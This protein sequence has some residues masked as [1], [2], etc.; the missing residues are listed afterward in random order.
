MHSSTCG[1]A[2]GERAGLPAQLAAGEVEVLDRDRV[3]QP[4][5]AEH[6]VEDRHPAVGEV[7]HLDQRGEV[8]VLAGQPAAQH[9]V[10]AGHHLDAGAGEVGV[11]VARG[12]E[13]RLARRQLQVVAHQRDD[14][15]RVAG[16]GLGERRRPAVGVDE[17]RVV[18][19]HEAGGRLGDR[20]PPAPCGACRESASSCGIAARRPPRASAA[21]V[22]LSS[23]TW[24][25]A[26]Q[27]SDSSTG[28]NPHSAS[29]VVSASS[30]SGLWNGSLKVRVGVVVRDAGGLL[31]GEAGLGLLVRRVRLQRQRLLGGEDLHQERQPVAEPL[32][33]RAAR[34]ARSGSL[35]DRLVQRRAVGE[36]ARLVGMGAHPQLGVRAVGRD[37]LAQELGDDGPATPGV[38]PHGVAELPHRGQATADRRP[39][40]G[41]ARRAAD[42]HSGSDGRSPRRA[43]T[44]AR[45][46]GAPSRAASAVW[47]SGI[48][49]DSRSASTRAA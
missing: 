36:H 18:G 5:R 34:A 29:K 43:Q 14:H 16:V 33:D 7:E 3:A 32:A 31:G 24:S 37:G 4:A 26:R 44:A 9:V 8:D 35:L 45:T 46:S 23:G 49:C 39:A 30:S 21:M 2:R 20:R 25:L 11:Q 42:R 1:P 48:R 19:G 27:C 41:R 13:H 15:A 10:R 6:R 47:S 28:R 40:V 17:L 12:Q 22:G 38:V